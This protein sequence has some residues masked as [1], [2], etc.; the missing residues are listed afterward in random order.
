VSFGLEGDEKNGYY[1]TQTNYSIWT[2][3]VG[4]GAA[5]IEKMSFVVS[6]VIAVGFGLPALVIVVGLVVAL[7][8]KIRNSQYTEFR[9][10]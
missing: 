9:E 4:L 2:F 6:L 7:V 1:Y 3:S 10:L 5:P 8:R